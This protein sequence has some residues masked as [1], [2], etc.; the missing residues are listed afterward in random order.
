MLAEQANE[1][2]ADGLLNALAF[3]TSTASFSQMLEQVDFDWQ[4]NRLVVSLVQDAGRAA[5]QASVALRP[6]VG[7]VRYLSPP[8][9]GRCAIL[10]GRVYRYSSSFQRHPGCDCTMIPTTLASP[11]F[12]H[13]PV[14]LARRGLISDL[15][16]ADRQAILDGADPARVINV[17]RERAGLRASGRTLSRNGRPTPEAIYA[18]SATREEA[19]QGLITAGYVRA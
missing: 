8:S 1:V 19:V 18:R 10:A 15:S 16:K 7:Y 14:D 12:I 3:T 9:C 13:D 6:R 4:F 17:R 11:D 2:A 5:E